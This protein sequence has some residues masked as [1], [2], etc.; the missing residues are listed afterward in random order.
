MP[1]N[2]AT[3][4]LPAELRKLPQW[5]VWRFEVVDDRE[6]KVPYQSGAPA[7]KASSTDP[8]TW[9][10]YATAVD[11][12]AADGIDGIGF[13]FS[14]DD[15]YSGIDF[16]GC[17][18]AQDINP[19]VAKLM[20]DLDSYTEFSPSGTGLHTF[21]KASV[22]GGPC[23]TSKT[24]W[25]DDFE[26]YDHGRFFCMTG[27]HVRDTPRTV[28]DRQRQLDAVRA[29][30]FPPAGKS[31]SP[32]VVTIASADDRELLALARG[33][34]NGD[35]FSA[36]YDA[37]EHSYG[38][39]SEADLA[40]CDM[41]A[42]W[43]GTDP[44]RIDRL[45]RGSARMREKWSESRGESTYGAQT[46]E[47]ALATRTEFYGDRRNASGQVVG[48]VE[49]AQQDPPKFVPASELLASL[50]PEPE[51]TW[52]SYLV[53]GN[54]TIL[55]GKP[56]AGKSTLAMALADAIGNDADVFLGQRING[57]PVLYV[58]EEASSTLAHKLPG[59]DVHLLTR[60]LAWPAPSWEELIEL[61]RREA[62]RVKAVAVFIDTLAHWAGLG[63]EREK[64]A[65]AAQAAMRPLLGLARDGLAVWLVHHARKGGGEDGEGLRG[66]GALAGAADVIVELERVGTSPRQR[67]LLALSRYPST[68]GALVIEHDPTDGTWSVV[69]EGEER[70]DSRSIADR[71]AILAALRR[72]SEL[73]TRADLEAAV[74]TPERQ[75]HP[76]L[77]TLEH[78]GLI[79]RTG[80]GKK[81]DPYRFGMLRTDAA[82]APAQQ[83][84]ERESTAASLSA[85]LPVREQHKESKRGRNTNDAHCA[86]R[87][88]CE[89]TDAELAQR[90][91]AIAALPVAEQDI[92]F[93]ALEAET[94]TE[95]GCV[96]SAPAPAVD[97][98]TRQDCEV[99]A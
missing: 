19:H 30:M 88:S 5:L 72:S 68:P 36:L 94:G 35:K 86:E 66:S 96:V 87:T 7:R 1:P 57:G 46:I 34:K 6:T 82:Q 50:P 16:D 99:S 71:Q 62:Q 98:G 44:G 97:R 15:P 92:A 77:T 79:Q 42:F 8:A 55:A 95:T 49:E 10:T 18:E 20:R 14:K 78:E 91:K 75:W 24:P 59:G 63:H 83:C 9:S 38:S 73:L 21:V 65:G 51:G 40:L 31:Q 13:V 39:D 32:P 12:A 53:P 43:T 45:F 47:K 76:E 58:A 54:V 90:V 17:V 29:R 84:A 22:N 37:A 80:A 52:G 27:R 33:A 56:K 25:A 4:A 67:A 74:G 85:A 2:T 3:D 70:S 41:L 60:D 23:R 48:H 81:G 93:A 64:D 11:A 61:T 89:L 28:N 69:G 26:N